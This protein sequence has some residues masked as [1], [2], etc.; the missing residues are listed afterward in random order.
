MR[1]GLGKS[2]RFRV[3]GDGKRRDP[4][5]EVSYIGG[6]LLFTSMNIEC[7]ITISGQ[8]YNVLNNKSVY[9]YKEF[10]IEA[11]IAVHGFRG[12]PLSDISPGQDRRV[13]LVNCT[14]LDS[15]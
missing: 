14:L 8:W 15:L 13:H 1:L 4:G 11:M 2:F 10:Y 3:Q 7:T 5:N 6:Y 9:P 12:L